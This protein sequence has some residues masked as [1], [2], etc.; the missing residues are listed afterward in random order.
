[1]LPLILAATLSQAQ[2]IKKEDKALLAGLQTHINFLADDKLEG[3]RTGT[4]GERQAALYISGQ[5]LAAGLQPKGTEGFYQRFEIPEGRQ[6]NAGTQLSIDDRP[7][8]VGSDFF[9]LPF[10]ANSS[11]TALASLSLQES[12]TPW[13]LDL[14]E[15]LEANAANPHFDIAE[16]LKEKVKKMASKGATAVF[17]YNTSATPDGLSFT[18]K[19][20]TDL[21]SIPVVYLS[22]QSAKKYLG[23]E[24]A[25]L[26]I[27]LKTDIGAKSRK[28]TN[29]VGYLDNG[30]ATT[31][32]LGAHFD[33]LGRGEDNNSMQRTGEPAIHN[34]ADDNASGTAALIEIA[35][36]LKA[37]KLTTSNYLFIA[38]SGEELGLFGSK[39]FVEHPTVDLGSVSFM[40]NMD[41]VGRLNDSSHTMTVGGYGTTPTWG[42]L[43]GLTGK[44]K[45][46]SGDLRFRFDSSGTGPSDH[47]SFYNKGIPVLFYFTG[48]HADYHRP[49]DDANRINY[50][51]ELQVVRHIY[52]L[53]ETVVKSKQRPAFTKTRDAQVGTSARFSVTLGIM[54]DYTFDGNGVRVD[55][56][57]DGRPA[58]KAGL[59]TGDV[60][61]ALG[62]Q[63][64]SSVES[65]MQALGKFKKGDRTMVTYTRNNKMATVSVE[66]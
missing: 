56:I 55:G 27:R 9:P 45:L 38:F 34:G 17:L 51:G 65:Y 24:S 23:D 59:Q 44:K 25:T 14:A 26:D 46:V 61:T 6:V 35:R 32:V 62:D 13:F 49:T 41:M 11:I 22:K 7:L 43:Y 10:S 28:G 39:Y 64:V 52:S 18:G 42:Q 50:M 31:I 4:E 29:V 53:V 20:K 15:M 33:H 2:K 37:S 58:Q 40:V 60:I 57:S 8:A 5:F 36:L 48:L 12:G 47:T 1:M 3:R 19:E 30:A 16:A 21:V 54:P 63:K 66:F